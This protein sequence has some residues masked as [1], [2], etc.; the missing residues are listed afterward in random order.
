MFP[1]LPS[2]GANNS[3]LE[4]GLIAL[5]ETMRNDST[6]PSKCKTVPAGYTYLGQF[7]DHDLTLDILPLHAANAQVEENPNYR[8]PFLDLDHLYGGG[9]T[10]SP[11]LYRNKEQ[12]RG[13]ERFLIGRTRPNEIG[14]RDFPCSADDLPRNGEGIA[15]TGDARQDEN[16][17]IAQLHVAFLKAHNWVLDKLENKQLRSAGPENATC[18]RQ[19]QRLVTWHYQWIV[20]NDYLKRILDQDVFAEI[21]DKDYKPRMRSPQ[22]DFRIPVEFSGA[23]FRFGHS[24]VRNEY[25]INET[26]EAHKKV[27]LK[28]ILNLTGARGGARPNLAADWKIDWNFFVP[29]RG[30][31]TP[32]VSSKIDTQIASGLYGLSQDTKRLFATAMPGEAEQC[33]PLA[34]NLG[35]Q[36]LPVITLLRGAR[37][38]LP[39]GQAVARELGVKNPLTD[40]EILKDSSDPGIF[41]KNAFHK[42]TPL[43]YMF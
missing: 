34:P 31:F 41:T 12:D 15:L 17:I 1:N 30:E 8:T 35:E 3:H 16:L 19:A 24:M 2:Q 6:E 23:A 36:D 28:E 39:S 40:E 5:G 27:S 21:T 18:F 42:D 26:D 33:K 38:A 14:N 37:M 20:R 32:Q 43:W 11:F 9:S 25:K 29:M 4:E 13:K 10:L 7:I 22:H